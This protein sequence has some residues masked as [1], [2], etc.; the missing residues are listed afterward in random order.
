MITKEELEMLK[1]ANN[2]YQKRQDYE[3]SM[4]T[5][6]H[7]S[8]EAAERFEKVID[9]SLRNRIKYNN[10]Q[11]E[12][13]RSVII[14]FKTFTIYQIAALSHVIKKYEEVGFKTYLL[15]RHLTKD[16][17]REARMVNPFYRAF[18]GDFGQNQMTSKFERS[19][20][21]YT[22]TITNQIDNF[23]SFVTRFENYNKSIGNTGHV[24]NLDFFED[25]KDVKVR[26]ILNGSSLAYVN[27]K[28]V[29]WK[30]KEEIVIEFTLD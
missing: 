15:E 18:N 30:F 26:D 21:I 9:E 29:N 11:D 19:E 13:K 22:K 5:F 27:S 23:I 1:N 7:S 14:S 25:Y 20:S 2:Q 10:E 3:Q 16:A 24:H 12:T 8:A 28:E 4:A 6:K 17:N